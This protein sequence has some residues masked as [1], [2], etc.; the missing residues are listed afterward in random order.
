M[1]FRALVCDYDGTVAADG[2]IHAETLDA[3]LRAR[4]SGRRLI[5]ATGRMLPDLEHVCPEHGVFDRLVVEN[6]AV[7]YSPKTRQVRY[8]GDPPSHALLRRLSELGVVPL[9]AGR[10]IVATTEDHRDAVEQSIVELRLPLHT[11]SNKGALMILPVGIDK[12][13]GVRVALASLDL[14]PHQSVAV[15]DAENDQAFLDACELGIA[16]GNAV[17][18]LKEGADWVTRGTDGR[19]VIEIIELLLHSDLRAVTRRIRNDA[20]RPGRKR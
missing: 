9:H 15:G 7:V 17:L 12:A 20:P 14:S 16:V 6:G 19:G 3:L 18:S 5:L 8:L 1:Q 10:V 13:A 4:H 11:I 2:T